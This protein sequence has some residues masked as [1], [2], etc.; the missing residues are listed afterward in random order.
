MCT[1]W[2]CS[3]RRQCSSKLY[4]LGLGFSQA[5]TVTSVLPLAAA[6]C[7]AVHQAALLSCLHPDASV[8][9]VSI[10][11]CSQ[12][13]HQ[14]I[15]LMQLAGHLEHCLCRAL[16]DMQSVVWNRMFGSKDFKDKGRTYVQRTL[17]TVLARVGATDMV[18][19]HTVQASSF[20]VGQAADCACNG[21]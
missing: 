6:C 15:G 10:C 2:A 3:L 18:I 17:Q 7:F 1:F 21:P 19:G 16:R 5:C 12:C 9:L 11:R 8:I 13:G 20:S 4:T 14:S